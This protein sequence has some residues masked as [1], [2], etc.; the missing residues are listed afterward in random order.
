VYSCDPRDIFSRIPVRCGDLLDLLDVISRVGGKESYAYE[1]GEYCLSIIL[2]LHTPFD[3]NE[4]I[5]S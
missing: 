1:L 4:S 3:A 5:R 2:S